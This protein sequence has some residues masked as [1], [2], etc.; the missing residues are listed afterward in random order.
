[1]RNAQLFNLHFATVN[2]TRCKTG[3]DATLQRLFHRPLKSLAALSPSSFV[4]RARLP[5]EPSCT[6][7]ELPCRLGGGCQGRGLG[8]PSQLLALVPESSPKV[9]LPFEAGMGLCR[10]H[11]NATICGCEDAKLAC[12]SAYHPQIQQDNMIFPS[13]HSWAG[14]NHPFGFVAFQP[15]RS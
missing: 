1:M 15:E 5:L 13:K 9:L 7:A 3:P 11:G 14:L 12:A 2:K 8:E 4:A 6:R 10:G